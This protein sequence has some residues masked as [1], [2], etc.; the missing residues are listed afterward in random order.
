LELLRERAPELFRLGTPSHSEQTI[1]T[2]W[3]LA[4]QQ[5]HKQS[6]T[7]EDLLT[8]SAFLGPDDIPLSLLRD[9]R[10]QLPERLAAAVRD[11]LTLRQA[12]AALGRYALATVTDQTL[13]VHRLVQ[14]V[15]R[16]RLD[17]QTRQA[18]ASRA[19]R[20]LRAAFLDLPEEVAS[21]P[22]TA[23]LLPHALAVTEQSDSQNA[24]PETTAI[25]RQTA[26]RLASR[27]E[28]I[29]DLLL[30]DVKGRLAKAL[31]G[32][33][34]R[35]GR[36]SDEGGTVIAM[37][38]THRDLAGMVGASRENVSRTLAAFRRRGLVD[39]DASAIR[40]LD[41]EALRRLT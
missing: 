16:Q 34:E 39:Y 26:K 33:A 2:T 11:R 14:A 23:R 35:H 9:Y 25:L 41:P 27:Q 29:N 37:R 12:T 6:P 28:L 19:T 38:L 7:A 5:L 32:L 40:L 4:L 8:L 20:L 10:D 15:V 22:V 36:P 21:R 24:E 30:L 13:S 31:L 3:T 1:A 18:W 17:D